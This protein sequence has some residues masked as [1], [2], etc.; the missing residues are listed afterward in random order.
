MIY[1]ERKYSRLSVAAALPYVA[2]VLIAGTV[3][4]L[5]SGCRT[6]SPSQSSKVHS[7]AQEQNYNSPAYQ[8]TLAPDDGQWTRPAKDLAS[9]RYTTLNLVTPEN[10]QNLKVASRCRW[11]RRGEQKPHP[12]GRGSRRSIPRWL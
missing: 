8:G 1:A 3:F 4:A 2:S 7:S 5:A 9:T 11:A 6:S 10:A 12:S